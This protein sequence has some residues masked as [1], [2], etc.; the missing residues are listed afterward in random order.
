MGAFVW[1]FMRHV[2]KYARGRSLRQPL[3]LKV[4]VRR[5]LSDIGTHRTLRRRDRNAGIAHQ[6]VFIG[7]VIAAVGTTIIF[8]DYDIVR[9]L[10][11]TQFW[12][13]WYYLITSLAL[14]LGHL[15][16]VAGLIYLL[17]RRGWFHLPKLDYVR[18]YLGE[19]S[20]RPAAEGWRIEDWAF[21]L[22]LLAIELTG[23]LQEGVRLL[24][25]QP[26]LADLSPVGAL[27]GKVLSGFGMSADAAA[28]IR[29]S[30]WWVH[31]ILALAFTAAIPWY[32]AKHI[33]A[34]V[35]SLAVRDEKPL[36]RL[37]REVVV[38]PVSGETGS[39]GIARISD[40]SWKEMLHLD[41]CTKCG[42]CHEAC[43]ARS[44][45]RPLSP[46]D[47]ILDLRECND[48][49]QAR[50]QEGIAALG[51]VI[52]PETLWA[53]MSCGACQEICPVGIEH[54]PLIVGMRRHLV[55]Q[56][57]MDPQLRAA[58]GSVA[59]TGNSFGESARKRSDWTRDLDFEIKDIRKDEADVLWF[60]G[61]Y[62]SF[63]PRNQKVSRTVAKLLHLAG[64]D[65][66]LL[67]ESEWTA[68]NDLRRAGEEGLYEAVVEHNLIEIGKAK[69][70]ARIMTTDPHSFNTIKNEYPE[71][72]RIAPIAHY[73]NVLAELLKSKRLK[74]TKPLKRRVT[75]HDPCHL[76]RL[77]GGYDPPREV[78]A[79]I[80][81]ELI[82][83][84]RSRDNSFCCG[85]GGG[86][87]WI[88]DMPGAPK[89]SISRMHEAA[90]LG[91]ID[92][93][94]T[95]CPKDLTMYEDARK[96]SGHE[97]S[98]VVGDIAEL[99]AEAIVQENDFVRDLPSI[100]E[101]IVDAVATRVGDVVSARM[102]EALSRMELS[103]APSADRLSEPPQDVISEVSVDVP[104][105][106]SPVADP[107]GAATFT[108]GDVF[109]LAPMD[110]EHPAP[111]RPAQ[112][113][114]YDIPPRAGSRVLVMI[115]HVASVGD[116]RELNPDGRDVRPA[117]LDHA[118]NEWDESALEEALIAVERL[119]AGEVV[120][121]SVGDD[122]ADA[123]LRRALA[124]GAHRAVRVWS[125]D[126]AGVDPLVIARALAGVAEIEK[127]DLI[128]CGVQSSDQSNGATGPA[129]GRVLGLPLATVV[130]GVDW[131][132][133]DRLLITRELEGGIREKIEL[134]SPAIV[135]VQSGINAPRYATMRMIKEAKRKT[136]EVVDGHAVLDGSGGYVVR[137]MFVPEV[138]K[139]E[140]LKGSS[141]DIAAFVAR[142]IREKS[143][144]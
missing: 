130:V 8:I 91:G 114:P 95:C 113:P 83:M 142:L 25:D 77:N 32:K 123:S 72:G 126:L 82:E 14:D 135:T 117:L 144:A 57:I 53:C 140:M 107:T 59:R 52:S 65:F 55:D 43:P 87:I 5:M 2:V 71:F 119:G 76:G 38:E 129:L 79:A 66:A 30:N 136:I 133:K 27:V 17:V 103:P 97:R 42:K 47:L 16:L 93:F 124:K 64:V 102:E 41:A 121:V 20:L 69:P 90:A 23:F 39:V 1:G 28:Q 94:V 48:R 63:D 67:H 13:G 132:G 10:F 62:A 105:A 85:A 7:F 89:P 26:H 88:P 109:D 100:A 99:V 131:D 51:D 118:M 104:L 24:M 80:G 4:G 35:G 40:L 21:L 6:A 19:T 36:A 92:V 139:A 112:L 45:E 54:P 84:P 18:R 34:V 110:W 128:F 56:D 134:S 50:D 98:F 61:D 49:A 81:C 111:I 122:G 143:G 12:R 96:T 44:S 101:R 115:K 74:V 141:L 37:P 60:V 68:G 86:R 116:E 127:P 120:A 29:L 70:F 125:P 73:T 33:L 106:S 137:R 78:L 108:S 31:G 3:E 22:S 75:F 58:F 11:G 138:A 15:G 9:L 46:R